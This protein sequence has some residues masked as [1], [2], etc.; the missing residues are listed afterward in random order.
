VQPTVV[1]A[2]QRVHDNQGGAAAVFALVAGLA[3]LLGTG[4]ATAAAAMALALTADRLGPVLARPAP[5]GQFRVGGGGNRLAVAFDHQYL[6]IARGHR[7]GTVPDLRRPS[8]TLNPRRDGRGCR[9]PAQEHAAQI[10]GQTETQAGGQPAEPTDDQRAKGVARQPQ[11][12]VQR[13]AAGTGAVAGN[14]VGAAV[15]QFPA[16]GVEAARGIGVADAVAA[17]GVAGTR[18]ETLMTDEQEQLHQHQPQAG[19]LR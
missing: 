15:T 1:A 19:Q 11:C 5:F 18:V 6:A 13:M 2:V 8:Q 12:A 17:V 16:G 7:A 3:L 4:L 10:A 9:C 14:P